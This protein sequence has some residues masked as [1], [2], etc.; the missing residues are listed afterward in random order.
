MT[1]CKRAVLGSALRVLTI[2]TIVLVAAWFWT[3]AVSDHKAIDEQDQQQHDK[4]D[5][6]GGEAWLS[7][8]AH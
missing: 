6:D 5:S 4:I 2:V 3:V 7:S 1:W 8:L